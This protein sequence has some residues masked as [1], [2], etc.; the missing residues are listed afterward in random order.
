MHFA[1]NPERKDKEA[2][3]QV[4]NNTHHAADATQ[5]EKLVISDVNVNAS[6]RH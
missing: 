1:N 2:C 3:K 6:R 4:E 5:R